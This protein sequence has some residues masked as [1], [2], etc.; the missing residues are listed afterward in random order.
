MAHDVLD[1]D[2]GVVDQD[3]HYQGQSEQGDDVERKAQILHA[4]EGRDHR[5]RQGDGGNERGA[6]IAQKQP[7]HDNGQD[8]SLIEQEHRA[9]EFLRHWRD[10]VVGFVDDKVRVRIAQLGQ[11]GAH[12]GADLDFAGP[13]AARDFKSHHRLPVEQGQRARFGAAVGD[14]AEL[15]QAHPACAAEGQ[16]NARELSGRTDIAQR[17]HRLFGRAKVEPTAAGFLLDLAQLARDVAGA[18]AERGQARRVERDAD[19]ARHAANARDRAH[20]THGQE[21]PRHA[22]VDKP[23]QGFV[24]EPF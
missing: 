20:P 9:V 7:H 6:P 18:N 19:L 2:D 15:I 23:R 4:H 11:R 8:R 13:A 1:L 21:A 3:A 5:Q 12:P 17:A 10:E 16:F 14:P 24:V 22:V